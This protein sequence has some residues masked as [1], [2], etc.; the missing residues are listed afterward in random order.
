MTTA[1]LERDLAAL[2][3]SMR[4]YTVGVRASRDDRGAGVIWSSDGAIVTNAHVANTHGV[5]IQFADGAIA[6]GTV[7]RR[8]DR[9]DLA[10]VRIDRRDLHAA[11]IR[12]PHDLRAGEILAALGHPLGV[13]NVL[14]LGIA[15]ATHGAAER[16]FVRADLALK[17]GNSGGPLSDCQ[18]RVVGINAMTVRGVALAV[19]SDD[20]RRFLGEEVVTPRL[21]VHLAP[22]L[23]R[24]GRDAFAV[25][26]VEIGSRAERSGLIL[27]DI[28]VT[29]NTASL[30]V[31]ASVDLVRGG[32]ALTLPLVREPTSGAAA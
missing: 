8:D 28:I 19:P 18:G 26:G 4:A 17:P 27:G 31:A 1:G 20:V 11:P 30:V 10:L 22:A 6:K 29:R 23:L 9:R 21:G 32:A 15:S 3:A 24:D 16:R 2:A 5:A 14:T 7:E 25:V 13:P 12:D